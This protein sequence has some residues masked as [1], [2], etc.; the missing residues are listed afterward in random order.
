MKDDL[1]FKPWDVAQFPSKEITAKIAPLYSEILSTL[2]EDVRIA[3]N[4]GEDK[5]KVQRQEV[6]REVRSL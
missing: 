4:L 6:R 3:Y 5:A 2:G 1:D